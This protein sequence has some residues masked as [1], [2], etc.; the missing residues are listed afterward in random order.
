MG[1]NLQG[2][3]NQRI[4]VEGFHGQHQFGKM[5][6]HLFLSAVNERQL[7]IKADCIFSE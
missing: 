2:V 1:L 4:S 3:E 5:V 6:A 7:K